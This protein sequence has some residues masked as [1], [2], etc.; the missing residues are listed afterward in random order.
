M[1]NIDFVFQYF[2]QSF[3]KIPES[4]IGNSRNTSFEKMIKKET[5]GK[6]VDIVLNSLAEDKL[7]A[8]IRCVGK[9]GH[10]IEI[11]RYDMIKNNP[12]SN[13]Y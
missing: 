10:F 7:H 5:N 1:K 11:G 8:S 4:Y 6:G 12:I 3:D 13:C 9:G 2:I